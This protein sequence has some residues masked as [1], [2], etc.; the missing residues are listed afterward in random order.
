MRPMDGE[1]ADLSPHFVQEGV[2]RLCAGDSGEEFL[3]EVDYRVQGQRELHRAGDEIV[4]GV[5]DIRGMLRRRDGSDFFAEMDRG[6]LV[7]DLQRDN[8]WWPCL[9]QDLA[10]TALNRDGRGILRRR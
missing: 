3:C 7:L 10:G 8:L 4:E 2:G 1:R 6:D 9:I 5:G